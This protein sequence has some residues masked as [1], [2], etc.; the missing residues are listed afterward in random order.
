M[1]QFGESRE[2]YPSMIILHSEER[3]PF[4]EVRKEIE[5][6]AVE[7]VFRIYASEIRSMRM[8]T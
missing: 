2:G 3:S 8:T 6:L 1:V 7:R 5:R 4:P